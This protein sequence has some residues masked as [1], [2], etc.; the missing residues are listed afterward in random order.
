M[1]LAAHLFL[2]A[3]AASPPY[4]P[5]ACPAELFRIGRSKNA[6]V[7]VY[8]AN[9]DGA[10]GLDGREP[11]HASWLLLADR[12]QREE[13]SF[14]EWRFAYGFDVAPAAPQPGFR[15]TFKA[16]DDRPLAIVERD[17]C[18]AAVGEIGGRQ[19]VLRRIF[20]KA[21]DRYLIPP[22]EYVEIFGK[23][24]DGGGDLYERIVVSRPAPPPE[25]TF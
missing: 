7:I 13:L 16:K 23:A 1:L 25:P 17:G 12:G 10:G 22:V 15:L 20:V 24:L 18:P 8:E 9:L 5:K 6:N 2:A 19:G 14:L 3:L 4:S 11:V 21:D